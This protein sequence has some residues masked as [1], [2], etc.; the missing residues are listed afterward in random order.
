MVLSIELLAEFYGDVI[1]FRIFLLSFLSLLYRWSDV[2]K[3]GV[4]LL[5]KMTIQ[6]IR[7]HYIC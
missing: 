3:E 1:F 5:S 4:F 6:A 7:S 2:L